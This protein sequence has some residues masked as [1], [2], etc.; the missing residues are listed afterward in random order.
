MYKS[1]SRLR[2]K[3][4]TKIDKLKEKF[5]NEIANSIHDIGTLEDT[6]YSMYHGKFHYS[7]TDLDSCG[8]S[9]NLSLTSCDTRY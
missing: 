2:R 8:D 9:D 7:M 3:V 6:D 1:T 4:K 5:N